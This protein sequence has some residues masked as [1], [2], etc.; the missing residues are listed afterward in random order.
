MSIFDYKYNKKTG[1]ETV[2]QPA[3]GKKR[4]K[5][6]EIDTKGE[7]ENFFTRNVK[8]ITFLVCLGIFLAVFGPISV[9]RIRDYI[10]ERSSKEIPM[11]AADVLTLAQRHD[12]LYLT[13]F[14]DFE[15]GVESET[16]YLIDVAPH[17]IVSVGAASVEA[18]VDHFTVT[19]TATDKKVDIM[20][21]DYNE[22]ALRALLGS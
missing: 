12:T 15:K 5:K 4:K 13:D 20:A 14:A 17:F 1:D 21:A 8:L 7:T 2:E 19:N 9:F 18:P 11:T 6:S 16:F 22:D 10:E 3:E